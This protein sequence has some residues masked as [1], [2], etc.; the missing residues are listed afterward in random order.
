MASFDKFFSDVKSK[1]VSAADF[2]GKKTTE[3]VET[4]KLKYELKQAAAKAEKLYTQIGT[5]VYEAKKKGE[6]FEDLIEFSIRELD[7]LN[8]R[9]SQ[10]ELEIAGVKAP[11]Q[12]EEYSEKVY[13]YAP[14]QPAEEGAA[15]KVYSFAPPQPVEKAEAPEGEAEEVHVY[16]PPQPAEKAEAPEGET[17]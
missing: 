9:M 3:A 13:S 5:I 10:L 14:P 1:A 6:D 16:A 4:G 7:E 12:K 2:A 15:E 17:E 8:E 11:E